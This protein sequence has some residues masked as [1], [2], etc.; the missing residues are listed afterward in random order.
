MN[1]FSDKERDYKCLIAHIS[2]SIFKADINLSNHT[3]WV[4]W[5]KWWTDDKRIILVEMYAQ[6][7]TRFG[8]LS[9][10]KKKSVWRRGNYLNEP[11]FLRWHQA[12][13]KAWVRDLIQMLLKINRVLRT[14]GSVF[15]LQKSCCKDNIIELFLLHLERPSIWRN[16]ALG[17]NSSLIY[18][19]VISLK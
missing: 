4:G 13:C 9:K 10:Q 6:S 3:T 19:E 14:L 17:P 15:M 1:P 16:G 7:V 2:L 18:T 11:I 12:I 5:I 8:Y